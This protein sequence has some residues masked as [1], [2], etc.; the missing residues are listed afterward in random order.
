M[1]GLDGMR[2]L[3]ADPSKPA[4]DIERMTMLMVNARIVKEHE[5]AQRG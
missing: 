5:K 3:G 1:N 4:D 2:F